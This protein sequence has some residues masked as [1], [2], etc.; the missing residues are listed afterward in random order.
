MATPPPISDRSFS[1][2]GLWNCYFL[3]SMSVRRKQYSHACDQLSMSPQV[4]GLGTLFF[5]SLI[6]KMQVTV[7]A[8]KIP[9]KRLCPGQ[10]GL[11]S[12]AAPWEPEGE[13]AVLE[14]RG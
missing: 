11:P 1:Y 5:F 9:A 12:E 7:D 2:K 3:Q 14:G 13:A 8:H 4:S 10:V 6:T